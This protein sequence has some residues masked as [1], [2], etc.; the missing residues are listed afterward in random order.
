LIVAR[1]ASVLRKAG[2]LAIAATVVL[3]AANLGAEPPSAARDRLIKSANGWMYVNG[4]WVHPDG[5]KFVNNK[6][7]RTTA[8]T[9]RAY[10]EPPGKL[11]QESP[12]KLAPRMKSTAASSTEKADAEKAAEV[13][14]KNLTPRP[15][16]QT[17]SHL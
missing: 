10:P 9:G 6:I 1:F 4:Q 12:A 13:R 16:P 2:C 7:V 8:K 3:G 5:Y 17:G 14:R 15:A 11:A